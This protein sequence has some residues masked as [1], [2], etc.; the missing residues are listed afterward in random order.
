VIVTDNF[1]LYIWKPSICASLNHITFR[2]HVVF[3]IK[4]VDIHVMM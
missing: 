1:S 2:V 3:I 4:E